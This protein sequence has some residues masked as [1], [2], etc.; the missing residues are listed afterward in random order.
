MR[1]LFWNVQGG[2]PLS[3][4]PDL[5]GGEIARLALQADADVMVFCE[6]LDLSLDRNDFLTLLRDAAAMMALD[7]IEF[8]TP[9]SR[10]L[11]R[12]ML[13]KNMAGK[14]DRGKAHLKLAQGRGRFPVRC[15]AKFDTVRKSPQQMA[16]IQQ[17]VRAV[18]RP[19]TQRT[20]KIL[21]EHSR[22]RPVVERAGVPKLMLDYDWNLGSEASQHNRHYLVLSKKQFTHSYV[23]VEVSGA[24]RQFLQLVFGDLTVPVIHAPAYGKGGGETAIQLARA[25]IDAPTQKVVAI[26][27]WNIDLEELEA[28]VETDTTKTSFN[29]L[30]STNNIQLVGPGKTIKSKSYKRRWHPARGQIT[31]TLPAT[32]KSG[33]TLD[34]AI[35]SPGLSVSVRIH[36]PLDNRSDHASIVIDI[37]GV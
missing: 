19:S 23:D 32:Q 22:I 31:K 13:A 17:A 27:D 36:T 28:E 9:K 14:Y 34:Y 33:G 30:F 12:P 26:G 35:A 4:S 29:K 37:Q 3:A 16:E 8:D 7:E 10:E 2:D 24:K 6:V 21:R 15:E 1:I 5:K 18:T 11:M 20:L 25:I